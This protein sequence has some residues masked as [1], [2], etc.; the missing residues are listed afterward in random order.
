MNTK[1]FENI[2]GKENVLARQ[3]DKVVYAADASQVEGKAKVI[4]LPET[5]EQVH[6]IIRYANRINGNIVI[7]GGGTGLAGGSVPQNSIVMDLSKLNRIIKIDKK[8]KTAVVEAGVLLDDLNYELEPELFF[9]I[10]PS[11]HAVCTIGGMVATNAAG[12]HAIKYGKVCEWVEEIEIIDGSGKLFKIKKDEIN[13][14]CGKEGTTG[15]I[16]KAKLKLTQPL[17]AKSMEHFMFNDLSRLARAVDNFRAMKN[18]VAIEFCNTV[19]AELAGIEAKNHLFVEFE[20]EEGSIKDEVAV[21]KVWSMREGLGPVSSSAGFI[22]MEDP[23]IPN[24]KIVEFLEWIKDND[25][26]CFGHIGLGIFHPR[27]KTSQKEL[28]KQMF[29]FVKDI[30]GDVSGEHGI[31][32]NKKE[33]VSKEIVDEVKALKKVYDPNNILN[34]GKII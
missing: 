15:I 30:G 14:F 5:V 23:R 27:F 25:L 9:P 24:D 16:V 26:P 32:L 8:N 18:V 12:N 20:S 34:V 22:I 13:D 29:K 28:V 10:R 21:E 4:V 3:A 6:K 1:S 7:K 31:G 19:C 33:F 2:V 11:S 17:K